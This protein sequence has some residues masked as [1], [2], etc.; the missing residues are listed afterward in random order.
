MAL[1]S[2]FVPEQGIMEKGW[3][4]IIQ[5]WRLVIFY[6]LAYAISWIPG[7]IYAVLN[8]QGPFG[9][10]LTPVLLLLATSYGPTIAALLTLA[11]LRDP[12]ETSAFRRHLFTWRAGIGW[13]ALALVLPAAL[14]AIG[15]LLSDA[16]SRDSVVFTPIAA[17]AFP[18]LLLANAGEEIGWRGFAFPQLLIPFG[19]LTASLIFGVLWAG[20]HLPLYVTMLDRF[21]ILIPLFVALSVIMAWIYLRTGQGVLIMLVFHSSLDTVQFVLPLG[22]SAHGTQTFAAIALTFVVA[23]ALVLLRTGPNLGRPD[24]TERS[25]QKNGLT[26]AD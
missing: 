20:L 10:P 13:Y 5:R 12:A 14:W 19:P 4:V 26:T 6:V 3:I 17:A 15:T 24:A 25:A 9:S 1:R 18:L 22:A 8:T 2:S 21:A 23:A 11:L 7:F 16:Y